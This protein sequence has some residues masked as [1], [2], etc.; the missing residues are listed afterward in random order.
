VLAPNLGWP[1]VDL[2]TP[3]AEATG[4]EVQLE[5]AANACVLS[6]VW[7]GAMP[8]CR[9]LIVVTVSEGIGAGVLM[10]GRLVRGLNG[11]AGEFGHVQL[12]PDGP[13]CGCGGRGCWEV[14]ASDHAALRYYLESV[15]GPKEAKLTFPDLLT[16]AD[17]GD[18]RAAKALNKMA[19]Y[20]ARG[21]KILVAGLAPEAIIVVGDLAGSWHHFGPTIEA[22]LRTNLLPGACPPRVIPANEGGVARLRGTVALV[23]QNDFGMNGEMMA[24]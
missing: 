3:I 4:L 1:E 2:R 23:L 22:G 12:D 5:N 11:M 10:N 17:L 14:F 6:A 8:A 21:M 7:F 19:G 24:F 15:R 16:R 9:N 18:A 13:L 20:L